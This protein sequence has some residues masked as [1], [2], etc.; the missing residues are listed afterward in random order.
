MQSLIQHAT[1]DMVSSH[2]A[3]FREWSCA[4]S[5]ATLVYSYADVLGPSAAGKILKHLATCDSL[6]QT[7]LA[8]ILC[9]S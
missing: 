7:P 2:A 6:D 3:I 1:A 9:F 8:S 5:Y 4:R